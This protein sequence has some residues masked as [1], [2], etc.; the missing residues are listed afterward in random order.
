MVQII[1]ESLSTAIRQ[2]CAARNLNKTKNIQFVT[3]YFI[4]S[5]AFAFFK[6]SNASCL[7]FLDFFSRREREAARFPESVFS[8]KEKY[9]IV[10]QVQ[11]KL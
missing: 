1:C 4:F 11:K 8:E 6:R 2:F 10:T 5:P 3:S 9:K 7:P